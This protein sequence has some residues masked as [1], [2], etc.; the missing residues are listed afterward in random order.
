MI[1]DHYA[2]PVLQAV[3][4]PEGGF[5]QSGSFSY[6]TAI[7]CPRP[8]QL[9]HLNEEL[10]A[11]L[12]G[13]GNLVDVSLRIKTCLHGSLMM[14][15]LNWIKQIITFNKYEKNCHHYLGLF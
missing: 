2:T 11:Y 4:E 9:L 8:H 12:T 3:L 14:S 10:D 15:G 1:P 6:L 13:S 7:L 5:P